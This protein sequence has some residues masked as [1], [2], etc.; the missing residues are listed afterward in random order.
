MNTVVVPQASGM[1]V[2]YAGSGAIMCPWSICWFWC[3]IFYL[4]SCLSYL[5]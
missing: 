4:F 1:Y 2:P 3:Y 5:L